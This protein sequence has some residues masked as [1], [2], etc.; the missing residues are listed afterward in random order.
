M[1]L[2][3][4]SGLAPWWTRVT[5]SGETGGEHKFF[6][7]PPEP[8]VMHVDQATRPATVQ[9]TV[10]GCGFPPGWVGTRPAFTIT[11]VDSNASELQFR[12]H[13]RT[14]EL[15]C[16][17]VCTRGWDQSLASLRDYVEAGCGSPYGTMAALWRRV[18]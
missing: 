1:T 7:G 12:H 13:G 16:A 15:D 9:W 11:P 10:T 8:C 5:G 4:V 18:R 3:T 6:F 14:P 2:T 17:R